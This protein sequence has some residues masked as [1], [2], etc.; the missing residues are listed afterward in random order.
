MPITCIG[1][2]HC[3]ALVTSLGKMLFCTLLGREAN[4]IGCDDYTSEPKQLELHACP[5]ESYFKEMITRV[6]D[7]CARCPWRK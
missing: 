3:K 6:R 1:C 5:C 4:W 7:V 2:T